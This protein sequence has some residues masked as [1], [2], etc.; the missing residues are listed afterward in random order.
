MAQDSAAA[1][2]VE[3][4]QLRAI[5]LF[6]GLEDE[7]LAWVRGRA[8]E[9]RI[10]AGDNLFAEGAPADAFYV[11][12][13]GEVQIT[14]EIGGQETFLATHAPGGF[15]G[16]VPLLTGTP[17]IATARATA[18]VRLLRLDPGA[19]KELLARCPTVAGTLFGALGQRVQIVEAT[20]RQQE[21]LAALGRLSA[22]LA[23]ELNNPVAAGRRAAEHLREK[24]RK[25]R[26][27]T[28]E[29]G[30][31]GLTPG[32]LDGLARLIGEIEG[33]AGGAGALDPLT[34]SDREG[35]LGDWLD[36]RDIADAWDLA[37]TLVG[38]GLTV[39]RLDA[40]AG[41]LDAA[42]LDT[43]VRWL[44][45]T[46]AAEDLLR[47]IEQSTGRLAELVG[48][49]KK[50]TY[51]DRAPV[52]EID[53]HDGIED[54][55]KILGYKLKHITVVREYDRA[56]PR[57]E[58]RGSELNQVW[59]NLLDNAADAI[60]DT[61]AGREGGGRITIRTAREPERV[62]VEVAD[63]GPGIPPEVI[64]RIC[65]PF[66]TTKG[67]G[68]GTGLGL[69][70]SYQIIVGK[71]GGDLHVESRPGDTRFQVRLPLERGGG[72]KGD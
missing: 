5:P 14:K 18:P 59:T 27:L 39:E 54:T 33:G 71:H 55:I 34:R 61:A 20:M 70:I 58:A 21:K 19:F 60:Y 65:E 22:G 12:L 4:D 2:V 3:L 9:V 62:L 69:D 42:A 46:L 63:N 67:V 40:L 57:I 31:H 30:R 23:H 24:V 6:A 32:Q 11:V 37:P 68:K 15:T 47:E 38:A 66:F 72:G 1:N 45:T 8:D 49:V 53:I 44:A 43:V 17:Y 16:E 48:A 13:D 29:L 41:A 64:D 10:A 26:A 52:Q 36:A 51:M 7:Q 35:E 28:L 50:Y 25:S 56:L